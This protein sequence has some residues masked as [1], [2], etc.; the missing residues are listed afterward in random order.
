MKV[1]AYGT[2][3]ANVGP[4]MDIRLN[5]TRVA[6]Q[7]VS[8]TTATTH[9]FRINVNAGVQ[10]LAIAFTNDANANGEDRNLIVDKVTVTAASNPPATPTPAPATVVIDNA[11][12]DTQDSAGGRTFTGK[13]CKSS[14]AGYYG[15]DAVQSCGT[16]LDSYRF[17]PKLM[18]ATYDVYV[19][20]T[21]SPNRSVTV[22]VL[23][24]YLSGTATKSVNQ[25]LNNGTWTLIGR[26]AFAAGT[27]GYVEIN[28]SKGEA[29][30]DAVR[31][32]PI[33]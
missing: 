9:T 24:R 25:Q 27:A 14:Q 5:G 29:S 20:W 23:V 15:V 2:K 6:G 30:A 31:F 4:N 16:S 19:R 3:V 28:D 8:A 18:A 21:S 10:K 17:T 26:Y 11:P 22:P 32:V 13:W 1:I 33:P 7:I 12:A